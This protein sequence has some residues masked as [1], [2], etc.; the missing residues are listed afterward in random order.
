M[1]HYGKVRPFNKITG[2]WVISCSCIVGNCYV[3]NA[4]LTLATLVWPRPHYRR[5]PSSPPHERR[6]AASLSVHVGCGHGRPSQLLLKSCFLIVRV[7]TVY[8]HISCCR[9]RRTNHLISRKHQLH[10]LRHSSTLSQILYCGHSTQY[11]HPVIN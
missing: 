1:P 4:K 10:R 2:K 6:T 5:G 3:S 8:R 11:S 9:Y 7:G